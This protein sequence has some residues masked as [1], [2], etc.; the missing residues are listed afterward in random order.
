MFCLNY[1]PLHS[2]YLQEVEQLKIN[3]RPADRTLPDFL[4]K[5]QDKS[6][7]IDI[8]ES[9]DDVD[10]EL[11]KGL[12]Q[13]YKNFKLLFSFDNKEYLE[14][15]QKNQLPFFFKNFVSTI[16][17]MNG[18]IQYHPTDMYICSEL[19]F[20]LDKVSKLL[21]DNNIKVRVFPNICQSS[22]SEIPSIKTFFIR[23][24]DIDIYKVF[25]DVFELISDQE[26]QQVIYK[27]YKQGKWF[28]EIG[29]IIPSFKDR[30]N[31]KY[32]LPSFGIIRSKCG[33]R[34]FYDP[35]VCSICDRFIQVSDSL[36]KNKIA[37]LKKKKNT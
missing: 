5:Y 16:D 31:S 28:G 12:Y 20:S 1:Y 9:F 17:Q 27:I 2:T 33:K 22:F 34:C 30:L 26:H 37:I 18:F 25:V 13:K 24:E 21:H 15:V 36:Q 10:A 32:L 14:R 11:F 19:G 35:S 23:P 4:E 8:T 29:A 3:Y 6:I 7:V